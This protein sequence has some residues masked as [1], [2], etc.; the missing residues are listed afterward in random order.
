MKNIISFLCFSNIIYNKFLNVLLIARF[1]CGTSSRT[2]NSLFSSIRFIGEWNK[3]LIYINGIG[4]TAHP[5]FRFITVKLFKKKRKNSKNAQ[6]QVP[7]TNE[8]FSSYYFS[9]I[10]SFPKLIAD[11]LLVSISNRWIFIASSANASSTLK[12][13]IFWIL[14]RIF[15]LVFHHSSFLYAK[16]KINI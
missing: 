4:I 6:D 14:N 3:S 9:S 8:I 10:S 1:I 5:N 12:W 7:R 15:Y 2:K 11:H 13:N 16:K